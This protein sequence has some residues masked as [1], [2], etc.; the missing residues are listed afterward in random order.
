M[1]PV[2]LRCAVCNVLKRLVR[3][4]FRAYTALFVCKRLMVHL[5]LDYAK[6][7]GIYARALGIG[8]AILID[9]HIFPPESRLISLVLLKDSPIII[10]KASKTRFYQLI[11]VFFMKKNRLPDSPMDAAFDYLSDRARTIREMEEKLDSLNYGEYEVNQVIER[12]KELN[13]LND[14]KYAQDFVATRLATKPISKRKLWT[15][16]YAHKLPKETIAYALEAITPDVEKAN[17]LEI[18]KKFDRQFSAI[19]RAERK[20]RVTR[21]LLGRGFSY[22][23][24]VFAL[25][26]VFGDAED[27]D[28]SA[29]AYEEDA[30]E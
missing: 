21:R 19:E 30:D 10:I 26:S 24:S 15:Q 7:F 4:P 27:V 11:E 18:A 25:E 1:L 17:A 14:E 8:V 5:V 6:V 12:L 3:K 29:N 9:S 23:A 2:V 28:L 13:Y 22:D 20:Q 16:L